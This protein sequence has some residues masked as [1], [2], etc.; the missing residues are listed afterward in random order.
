MDEL[1]EDDDEGDDEDNEVNAR[2]AAYAKRKQKERQ[3]RRS[4]VKTPLSARLLLAS[5][6]NAQHVQAWI[7]ERVQRLSKL[8]VKGR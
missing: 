2:R 8:Y 6:D 5:G 4:T 7:E 1:N 3:G